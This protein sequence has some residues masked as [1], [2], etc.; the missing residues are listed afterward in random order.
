M[1]RRKDAGRASEGVAGANFLELVS[2][3]RRTPDGSRNADMPALRSART[4]DTRRR[5]PVHHSAAMAK[6]GSADAVSG[7]EGGTIAGAGK[8]F[9]SDAI[10][11]NRSSVGKGL[12]T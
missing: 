2:V 10:V 11:L 1:V 8:P 7:A 4:G 5:S 3:D 9:A 6:S 12:P